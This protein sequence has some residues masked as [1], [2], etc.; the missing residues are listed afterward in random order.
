MARTYPVKRGV[1]VSNETLLE[2]VKE[3]AGNGK[4]ENDHVVCS[5]P[6]LKRIELFKDGKNLKVETESDP[7]NKN[8]METV[9]QFNALVELVTG[10]NT[11]E[12]K[13]RLSKV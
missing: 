9:K 8:P 10:F 1:D 2:K 12:R 13:K 4:I 7:D 11:K 5:I 6:G 3:H